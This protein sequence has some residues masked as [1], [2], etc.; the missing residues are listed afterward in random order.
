MRATTRSNVDDSRHDEDERLRGDEFRPAI[1]NGGEAGTSRD[2]KP[3][4][5][6]NDGSVTMIGSRVVGIA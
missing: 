5:G 1:A 2:D 4:T 6:T 3:M